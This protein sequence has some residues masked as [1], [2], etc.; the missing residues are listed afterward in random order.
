MLAGLAAEVVAPH[1]V[2]GIAGLLGVLA[3]LAIGWTWRVAD[4]HARTLHALQA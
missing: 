4:G 2:V 3:V 1:L